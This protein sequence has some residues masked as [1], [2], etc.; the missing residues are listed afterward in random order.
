MEIW[1]N[2]KH[3]LPLKLYQERMLQIADFL[4]GIK[5]NDR[6]LDTNVTSFNQT[7]IKHLLQYIQAGEMS[8]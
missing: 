8:N 3:R 1:R 4:C 5:V 7:L 2:Y 6:T